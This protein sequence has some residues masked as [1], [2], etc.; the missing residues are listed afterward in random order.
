MLNPVVVTA[1]RVEQAQGDALRHITVITAD[2]IRKSQAVDLPSLLRY[3]A[4][5]QFT[6]T[7]GIGSSIGLFLRGAETRHTLVL[8][9]G[10]PMTKQDLSG[11]ASIEHIMLDNID[12]IE[13][14]RGNV[15]AI[16]GSGAIGG[17]IQIFTKA[18]K[19][20]AKFNAGVEVGSRDTRKYTAGVSGS[21]NAFSYSL[22]ASSFETDGFSAQNNQQNVNADPDKDGYRNVS[23]SGNFG[24]QIA[25]GHEVGL[26]FLN[27]EGKLEYDG[28]FDG[29]DDSS[30]KA[31]VSS[32]TAYS[33]N[34]LASNWSSELSLS[35]FTD[36]YDDFTDGAP[37][38]SWNGGIYFMHTKTQ[39]ALWTNTFALTPEWT[40]TGGLEYRDESLRDGSEKSRDV[41][42]IFTGLIGD[43]DKHSVQVNV[44]H[45][46]YSDVGSADTGYVG[47]GYEFMPGLKAIASYST[48]FSAAP[49]GYLS[50]N[51]N[52]QPEE[53]ES[54][55]LGLQYTQEKMSVRLVAFESETRNQFEWTNGTFE[56]VARV[57]N[58][59]MEVSFQSQIAG[60][61]LRSSLTLQDPV[62]ESTGEISNRRAKKMASLGLSKSFGPYN[63]GTDW[64]YTGAR[65]DGQRD[66]PSYVLGHVTARYAIN[67]QT[68]VIARV[69]NLTDKEYQT[70]YGY[71]QA[72]RS[73]FLG[74]SWQQ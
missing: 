29:G 52:L 71:N 42:A 40:A 35:Q 31:R 10:V 72:P 28:G 15:S 68:S 58:Q 5:V 65:K 67:K 20:P 19:G 14:V 41:K 24:Y 66:L 59:G 70:A 60:A 23:V 36:K 17:V 51:P 73:F 3:Q 46:D 43:F 53:V 38:V 6:Q 33:R 47:Y 21:A 61:D 64:Q 32:Y 54:Q 37:T 49:F 48:S 25:S 4:G 26:R 74:V 62:N 7:G 18:G 63:L 22:S 44:R 9:D 55:E 27:S 16:Y 56:N 45:D 8:V 11:A 57:K 50:Y 34:R 30:S 1:S 13:I 12:R 2:D 39:Q 69:E